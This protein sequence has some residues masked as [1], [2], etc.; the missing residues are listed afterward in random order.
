[1][2]RLPV[3]A[4]ELDIEACRI[5]ARGAWVTF[6]L[7]VPAAGS[8]PGVL[9]TETSRAEGA[10]PGPPARTTAMVAPAATIAVAAVAGHLRILRMR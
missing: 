10:G 4:A 2:D 3:A 1:V 7:A 5:A 9:A 8:P 6:A